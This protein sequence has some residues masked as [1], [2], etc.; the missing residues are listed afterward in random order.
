MSKRTITG[1]DL[2]IEVDSSTPLPY[3]PSSFQDYA[4][5]VAPNGLPFTVDTLSLVSQTTYLARFVLK[6]PLDATGM[7]VAV[8]ASS[9]GLV[10]DFAVLDAS[11]NRLVEVG[12][13]IGDVPNSV[14]RGAFPSAYTLAPDTPYYA[15]FAATFSGSPTVASA[16]WPTSAA[17]FGSAKPLMLSKASTY[18]IPGQVSSPTAA[19]NVPLLGIDQSLAGSGQIT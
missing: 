7:S 13:V 1:A 3:R 18:P 4:G 17:L 2:R 11:Y 14:W 15:A 19:A 5:T 16:K 8:V 10:A 12:Q 6:E 9:G